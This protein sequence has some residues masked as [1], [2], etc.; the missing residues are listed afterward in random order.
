MKKSIASAI[1]TEKELKVLLDKSKKELIEEVAN[2]QADGY[3]PI[4]DYCG[5]VSLSML[6]RGQNLSAEYY[7]AGAQAKLVEERI[8]PAQTVTDLL[9]RV[10]DMAEKKSTGR[11]ALNPQTCEVLESYLDPTDG[12]P[13]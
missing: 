3:K 13:D 5:V 1:E 12:E 9:H 7:L 4:N 6:G 11:G 10:D 8:A 2:R